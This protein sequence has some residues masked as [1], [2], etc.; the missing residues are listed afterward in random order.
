MAAVINGLLKLSWYEPDK[1]T[2]SY[3]SG[4]THAETTTTV[5]TICVEDTHGYNQYGRL[6]SSLILSQGEILMVRV[7]VI[8]TTR[9]GWKVDLPADLRQEG[10]SFTEAL[11]IDPGTIEL[12]DFL[13]GESQLFQKVS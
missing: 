10:W 5:A 1:E 4:V 11:W 7:E 8:E 6:P 3:Y 12:D 2:F 9:R 13:F